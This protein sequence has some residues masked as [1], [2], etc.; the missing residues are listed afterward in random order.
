MTFPRFVHI[1]RLQ[2]A[3]HPSAFRHAQRQNHATAARR[4]G[5]RSC[6]QRA[7]A[8]C[9]RGGCHA[10]RGAEP[11]QR[12]TAVSWRERAGSS[13][14]FNQGASTATLWRHI[15]AKY[16][17]ASQLLTCC[18]LCRSSIPRALRRLGNQHLTTRGQARAWRRVL[19]ATFGG[20]TPRQLPTAVID[21]EIK[22]V[23][24]SEAL[25]SKMWT[26]LLFYPKVI[27]VQTLLFNITLTLPLSRTSRLCAPRRSSP[28]RTA[29]PSFGRSTAK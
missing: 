11:R 29:A 24:M 9:A 28:F 17:F 26:V 13:R 27:G 4:R 7:P 18:S 16:L 22:S 2:P 23:S 14:V 21:G 25:N 12:C 1:A 20:L 8:G 10:A 6:Q 5:A 3:A 15:R 19:R